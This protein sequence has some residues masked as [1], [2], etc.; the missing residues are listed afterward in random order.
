MYQNAKVFNNLAQARTALQQFGI[1]EEQAMYA[2]INSTR[3]IGVQQLHVIV[4]KTQANK[5]KA[6]SCGL[7]VTKHRF[8]N[9]RKY[10]YLNAYYYS[11]GKNG[12]LA[13]QKQVLADLHLAV[14]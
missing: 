10:M 4:P 13:W 9:Y 14:A 2:N 1:S 5:T 6:I 8:G 11:C 3:F 7:Q 12:C